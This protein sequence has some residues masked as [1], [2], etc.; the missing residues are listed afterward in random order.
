M[1]F[2]SIRFLSAYIVSSV[3]HAFEQSFESDG[4]F[5]LPFLLFSRQPLS[6]RVKARSSFNVTQRLMQ[7]EADS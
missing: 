1:H 5:R 2:N 4:S 3:L 7:S 6:R